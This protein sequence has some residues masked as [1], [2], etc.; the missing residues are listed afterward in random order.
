MLPPFVQISSWQINCRQLF[1][2]IGCIPIAAGE[3][4]IFGQ[5]LPHA[6]SICMH[7]CNSSNKEG[8]KGRPIYGLILHAGTQ[9]YDVSIGNER[10]RDKCM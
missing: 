8:V 10:A 9:R 4:S 3:G 1:A 5:P 2:Q 7:H 6:L